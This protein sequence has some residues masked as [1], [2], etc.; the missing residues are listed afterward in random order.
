MNIQWGGESTKKVVG[1]GILS[2]CIKKIEKEK[3]KERKEERERAPEIVQHTLPE[4]SVASTN[5]VWRP[6]LSW[7]V[8]C[9]WAHC[10]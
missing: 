8:A 6:A 2:T 5:E 3:E 9:T 7:H 4:V 10:K 1:E